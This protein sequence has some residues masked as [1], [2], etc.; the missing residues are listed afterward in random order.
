MHNS[1]N[2]KTTVLQKTPDNFVQCTIQKSVKENG[3]KVTKTCIH[4]DGLGHDGPCLFFKVVK[5][6]W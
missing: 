3:G 2:S 5:K 4:N 1:K 6:K